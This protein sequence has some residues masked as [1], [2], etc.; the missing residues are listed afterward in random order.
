MSDMEVVLMK[1]IY[2]DIS[3]P[4]SKDNKVKIHNLNIINPLMIK[5]ATYRLTDP[6]R[7]FIKNSTRTISSE[8]MVSLE[9]V[10]LDI[11]KTNVKG[12]LNN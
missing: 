10:L 1:R 12:Q 4:H 11:C 7:V 6:L 8:A 5:K 9:A 2:I 3:N